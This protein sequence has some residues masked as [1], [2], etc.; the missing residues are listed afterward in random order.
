MNLHG[1]WPSFCKLSGR[2]WRL[3]WPP[4][5]PH[6][7]YSNWCLKTAPFSVQRSDQINRQFTNQWGH[8]PQPIR[9]MSPHSTSHLARQAD[10]GIAH[11]KTLDG[12]RFVAALTT[13]HSAPEPEPVPERPVWDWA[14]ANQKKKEAIAAMAAL[15]QTMDDIDARINAL[16]E[17]TRNL[18][19]D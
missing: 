18:A 17:R 6:A 8:L 14:A 12:A 16:V 9:A 3:I 1:K 10:T 2:Y 15:T 11:H 5:R 4:Y 7:L 19:L 13:D